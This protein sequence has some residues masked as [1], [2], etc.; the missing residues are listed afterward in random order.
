[1]TKGPFVKGI[2][3]VKDQLGSVGFAILTSFTHL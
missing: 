3:R 2:A 1:M